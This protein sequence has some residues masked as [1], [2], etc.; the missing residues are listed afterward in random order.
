MRQPARPGASETLGYV[1]EARLFGRME[2]IPAVAGV[3]VLI[4][5]LIAGDAPDVR[6]NAIILRQDFLRLERFAQDC[7]AS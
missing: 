3:A 5:L 1:R 6:R 2:H 7:A 4:K